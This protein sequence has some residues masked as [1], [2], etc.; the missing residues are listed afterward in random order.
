M[1]AGDG[2]ASDSDASEYYEATYGYDADDAYVND[3]DTSGDDGNILTV[4]AASSKQR[5]Q[6]TGGI[7]RKKK[8][9]PRKSDLPAADPRRMFANSATPVRNKKD[10]K[11][12]GHFTYGASMARLTSRFDQLPS[13]LPPPNGG[14]Y[15]ISAHASKFFT[16]L[17]AL[18][19]GSAN[20]GIGGRDMELMSYNTDG[21]RVNIGIAG[22]HQM[23]G[24]QLGTFCAVIN[25]QLG[26]VLG[27]FHQ[28]AH[29]PEQAKYIH[30]R[31]QFQAH[32]N[33]V[34]DTATIYGGP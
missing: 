1:I 28:Y 29:V 15:V 24:K 12:I 14:I 6:P 30:S 31:C 17:L 9:L 32:E 26:R 11:I 19:D 22:D 4:N 8:D 20:G 34:G 3:S 23:T 13:P 10:G 25:T 16:E 7:L 33:L 5:R 2:Y 21:R 27:I 18:M